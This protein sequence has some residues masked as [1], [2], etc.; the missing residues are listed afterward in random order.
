MSLCTA[1]EV[2]AT[3]IP[4]IS[5]GAEDSKLEALIDRAS[6]LFARYCGYPG[7]VPTMESANYVLYLDGP[8]GRDLDLSIWPAT[9]ISS[10]YDDPTLD[11]TDSAYLVSS[12]DYTLVDGRF[13]RLKST[14][15]HGFWSKQ[16]DCIKV[17]FTAGYTSVPDD[18]KALCI[19]QVRNLWELRA[20]QG[21][22]KIKEG[23][24]S[25]DFREEALMPAWIQSALSAYRLPR[26]MI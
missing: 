7:S 12:S 25:W 1:T 14:A 4:G 2:R 5:G 6:A 21:K 13:L 3:G 15:T 17:S 10:V 18:L 20:N 9:A 11:F 8:G 16:R 23:D 19:A 22:S 26:S 24:N